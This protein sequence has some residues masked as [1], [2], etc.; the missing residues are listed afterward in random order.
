MKIPTWG[1][2]SVVE[3]AS[4][5]GAELPELLFD[6]LAGQPLRRRRPRRA[7]KDIEELQRT[8]SRHS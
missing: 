2:F 5:R 6:A 7:G 4:G 3:Q 8:R 1:P